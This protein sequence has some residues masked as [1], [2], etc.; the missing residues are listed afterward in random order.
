[1]CTKENG[2]SFELSHVGLKTYNYAINA[3]YSPQVAQLVKKIHRINSQ[4]FHEYN[5][6][7]MLFSVN[8]LPI[9]SLFQVCHR[10]LILMFLLTSL[11]LHFLLPMLIAPFPLFRCL[12]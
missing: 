10:C 2:W 12:D 3:N 5:K 6:S 4:T 1:M 9:H 8:L 11:S 7:K